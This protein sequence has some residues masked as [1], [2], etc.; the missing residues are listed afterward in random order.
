[1]VF[2]HHTGRRNRGS[3]R[4]DAGCDRV[5]VG[6][7]LVDELPDLELPS[8]AGDAVLVILFLL[9][10]LLFVLPEPFTTGA[11]AAGAVVLAPTIL[12]RLN[13]LGNGEALLEQFRPQT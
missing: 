9:C 8:W 1:M 10:I 12:A 3:R 13:A 11:G 7:W 2:Q 6:E 5:N 4:C